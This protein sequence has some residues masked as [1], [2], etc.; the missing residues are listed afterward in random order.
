MKRRFLTFGVILTSLALNAQIEFGPKVGL[1]LSNQ[2]WGEGSSELYGDEQSAIWKQ[3]GN[4][5]QMLPGIQIGGV[6]KIGITESFSIRPELLFNQKGN[7]IKIENFGTSTTR[8]N[9]LEIP[10]NLAYSFPIGENKL[11]LFAGPYAAFGLGGKNKFVSDMDGLEDQTNT[12]KAAKNPNET[13]DEDGYYNPLELGLNLGA[14]FQVS[15]LYFSASY[16][17][18]LTNATAKQNEY[19]EGFDYGDLQRLRNNVLTV[20]VAY[21]FGG[22]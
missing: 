2:S 21:M 1:N 12:L 22:E 3:D 19:L 9:Y 13:D 11:D 8:L 17:L 10:I 6:V 4:S 7:V 5:Q 15:K 20:G 16:S 14:G 18:G